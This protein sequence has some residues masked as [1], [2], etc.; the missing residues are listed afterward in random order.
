MFEQFGDELYKSGSYDIEEV[1]PQKIYFAHHVDSASR[2]KWC[3]V[4]FKVETNETKDEFLCE[5][6][7]FAHSGMLCCHAIKVIPSNSIKFIVLIFIIQDHCQSIMALDCQVILHLRLGEIPA[8]HVV[9][10]WTRDARDILPE[11]LVMYQ[12]DQGRPKSDTTRH[13]KLYLSALEL[14]R[15][16]DANV[17]SYEAAILLMQQAKAKLAPISAERDG[18][19]VADREAAALADGMGE[20]ELNGDDD[21]VSSISDPKRKR[22]MGRPTTSR[23]KPPYEKPVKRSR[24]CKIC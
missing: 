24:F 9:K 20:G 12:N 15:M 22:A 10:R 6:G 16:G 1:V 21:V 7:F 13:T 18:M 14:V 4:T 2:E 3:R 23:D 11:D 5:C 19:G 8:K 17:Q